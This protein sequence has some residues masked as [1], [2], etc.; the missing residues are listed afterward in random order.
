MLH[1]PAKLGVVVQGDRLLVMAVRRAT[2]DTFQV[3][4]ENPSAALRAELDAR[5]IAARTVAVGLPRAAVSVKPVELP[6]VDG[7]VKD[8]LRYELERHLPFSADDA[9]FDFAPLP[10]TDRP[11]RIEGNRSV[12]V[13]AADRHYVDSVLRLVQEAN[14]RPTSIT[15]AAHDLVDLVTTDRRQHTV[16]LHRTGDSLDLVFLTGHHVVLSRSVTVGDAESLGDEIRRSLALARW[17]TCDAVWMSGDPAP[18]G[19]AASLAWLG[20]PVT[21]PP[22]TPRAQTRLALLP[23]E[24]RGEAELGLAVACGRRARALDIIPAALKP[25]RITRPQAITLGSAAALVL[26]GLLALLVPGLREQRRLTAI[27]A[28]IARLD[29]EVRTIERSLRELERRQKL[30]AVVDGLESNA[31]RP[32]P[33]LRELTDI[34]PQDAWL[35]TLT[36][37]GKGVE[38]TGQAAA[39]SGLIPLLENSPRLERVE[40]ASPVTRGRDREQFR[41]RAAWEPGGATLP[42]TPVRTPPPG[43]G[44]AAREQAPGAGQPA[45]PGSPVSAEPAR[46]A[47]PAPP[48]VPRR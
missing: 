2:V 20:A 45:R 33:V 1:F 13:V 16:W 21:A 39:A 34:V 32:L 41:I 44:G 14:L 24:H 22:F 37:D 11:E 43:A 10:A 40:F 9:P 18:A 19:S 28:E 7:D 31:V 42:L 35:T 12:L 48:E 29:P 23:A 8:V 25:R 30:L 3:Q 26:I 5:G 38:L 15:V 46:P 47:P 4:S 36:L 27:N 6:T 17:R